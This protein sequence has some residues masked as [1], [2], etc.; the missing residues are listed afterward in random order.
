MVE[1]MPQRQERSE[2]EKN[3]RLNKLREI[4]LV[5]FE[6]VWNEY[7][8]FRDSVDLYQHTMQVKI[9]SV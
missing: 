6:P 3:K 4:D 5:L 9:A 1:A 7:S 8:D 2:Q